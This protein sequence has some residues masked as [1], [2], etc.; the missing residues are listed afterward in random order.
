PLL[1]PKHFTQFVFV[2][3][4][5]VDS[6]NFKGAAE[7][8]RLQEETKENLAR[9]VEWCRRHGLLADARFKMD[10]E[11]VNGIVELCRDVL[12]DFPRGDAG[13]RGRG[14][15]LEVSVARLAAP[16]AAPEAGPAR[17]A[18]RLGLGERQLVAE[19]EA[20]RAHGTVHDRTRGVRTGSGRGPS[21][22]INRQRK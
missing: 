20:D 8:E 19:E 22:S 2:S 1:F 15:D 6:G 17:D 4:A 13:I 11:A 3:V 5:V 7:V 9:Y 16:R 21:A 14:L 18:G 12:E 10:T